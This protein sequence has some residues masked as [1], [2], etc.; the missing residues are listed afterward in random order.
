M[1]QSLRA[2]VSRDSPLEMY[3]IICNMNKGHDSAQFLVHDFHHAALHHK[4]GVLH[5]KARA[6]AADLRPFKRRAGIQAMVLSFAHG[7]ACTSA[8]GN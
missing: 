1:F 7:R 8:F 2:F 5:P 3:M 4:L 6:T